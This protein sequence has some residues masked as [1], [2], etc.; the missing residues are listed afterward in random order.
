MSIQYSS[1]LGMVLIDHSHFEDRETGAQRARMN[2]PKSQRHELLITF[3]H[4]SLLY[5]KHSSK[6]WEERIL[7]HG[8]LRSLWVNA[9]INGQEKSVSFTSMGDLEAA[10]CATQKPQVSYQWPLRKS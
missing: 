1:L 8:T 6:P 4:C 2:F 7:Q 5:P 9:C 3:P 10:P